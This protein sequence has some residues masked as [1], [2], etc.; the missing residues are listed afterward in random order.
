MNT[1][2][3][4]ENDIRPKKLMENQATAVLID[5]GRL[6]IK[7]SEFVQVNCPA[8]D[9]ENYYKKYNKYGFTF[10]ECNDCKT[11]FTNPRPTD[12]ILSYFYKDSVNY[13]YWN[14]HVF[15]A[16]E[17]VRRKKIFVPRVD[18]IEMF[19]RK[20]NVATN[21]LLEIGAGF[22]TFCLEA[23]SRN[24]FKRIVA[25]EPTPK[26]AETCR[27]KGLEVIEDVIENITFSEHEKF[28]VVVNFEVIEHLFS[29]KD[30]ILNCRRLLKVGGLF[31]VTCPNGQGF[32]F[33]VLG[34]KCNSLDHEHLNYFNP[35]SLSLLLENNGFE[36]LESLT[37][38]KLDADLV[39]TKILE[40]E[41]DVK[42]NPF[43]MHV[44]VERWEEL[45]EKF[46]SFLAENNLS[47][48]MWIV[49]RKI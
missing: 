49:A 6:L 25:V 14:E 39:R 4:N 16:S 20:Y 34:E 17:E 44:L 47:S 31:V 12:E 13:A 35:K 19:C 3:F 42:D 1:D 10:V 11:I 48:H 33:M 32:D 2:N 26:L 36:V 40:G 22:G 8:C 30:F 43:L 7:A 45:G 5:I 27:K 18:K 24:T 21:N 23:Q 46:Q 15:P 9:S 37:P 38:G 29:P 41:L 28:D